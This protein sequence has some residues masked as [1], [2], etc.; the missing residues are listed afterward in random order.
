MGF[1]LSDLTAAAELFEQTEYDLSGLLML[2]SNQS[3]MARSNFSSDFGKVKQ[4]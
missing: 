2:E 4:D 3:L 1:L